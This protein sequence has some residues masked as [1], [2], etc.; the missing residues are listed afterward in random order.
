MSKKGITLVLVAVAAI[1]LIYAGVQAYTFYTTPLGPVLVL[2]PKT[3][4]GSP[5]KAQD[6]ATASLHPNTPI[7]SI[8][9]GH[10]LA[11]TPTSEPQALCGGPPIMNI[12][13][14]GS[15]ARGNHYLYGLSD[16]MRLIR[17]DF[18]TPRVTI[19]E[20]PRDMWVEIP[21]ISA[22]Y[23]ITHGK[24][25]Q[26]YLYGNPGLGYYSGKG[27]GPEL[28]AKTL[29]LNFG[30]RPDHY[31][32]VNMVTFSAIV[33]ALGGLDIYLP[34]AVDARTPENPDAPSYSAGSHHMDGQTALML[35]RIRQYTVFGR[36]DS[37]NIVMCSLRKELTSPKVVPHI[38]ELVDSFKKYVQ[39][40]FSP[41]QISQ[42]ACLAPKIESKNITFISFPEKLFK[43]SRMYDPTLKKEVFI[44]DVDFAILRDY[45]TQFNQG[46]WPPLED[47][48]AT[49]PSVTGAIEEYTCP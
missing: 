28:L 8:P 10:D 4:A 36:A 31:L 18:V 29:D 46:T 19:L 44:F 45:V 5:T 32:A 27:Q 41:E 3:I 26:A 22:H 35:A 24:L 30:I 47:D 43:R 33:D 23:G 38:P 20:I 15:D 9:G 40:D 7:V 21:E 11:S 12:L 34:Y 14:I 49:S 17:V 25:N 16:V 37:Q 1:V 39:T 2:G 13:G 42:L 48:L 6:A